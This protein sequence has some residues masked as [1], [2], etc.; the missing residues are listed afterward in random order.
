MDSLRH[1]QD[2]DVTVIVN[3]LSVSESA[4]AVDF[5][6]GFRFDLPDALARD[7]EFFPTSSSVAHAV[8]QSESHLK[9][10]CSRGLRSLMIS[11]T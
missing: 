10:F 8:C 4:D 2:G 5:F 7:V 9:N 11:C 6:N 3:N 1:R